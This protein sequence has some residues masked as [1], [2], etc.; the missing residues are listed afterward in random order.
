MAQGTA[1]TPGSVDLHAWGCACMPQAKH[2]AAA[3]YQGGYAF[4]GGVGSTQ[5]GIVHVFAVFLA[6]KS[7]DRKDCSW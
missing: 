4:G 5:H 1:G 2:A 3:M 6:I 7:F